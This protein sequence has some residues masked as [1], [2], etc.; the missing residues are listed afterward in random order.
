MNKKQLMIGDYVYYGEFRDKI[1]QISEILENGVMLK[2]NGEIYHIAYEYELSPVE[3]TED[4]LLKLGFVDFYN[5]HGI[6]FKDDDERKNKKVF[7]LETEKYVI[8]V[9]LVKQIGGYMEYGVNNFVEINNIKMDYL[10]KL[11]HIFNEYDPEK[12]IKI[13]I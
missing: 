7:R 10:Y 3:I 1:F 9:D 11:Q 5:A 2:L 8:I 13:Q 12:E 4:I 6:V